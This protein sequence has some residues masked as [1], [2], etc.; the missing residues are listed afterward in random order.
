M[1]ARQLRK[2][3]KL[4]K[5]QLAELDQGGPDPPW[6]AVQHVANSVVRVH[7]VAE[8][9]RK[10]K[11]AFPDVSI[12]FFEPVSTPTPKTA[13]LFKEM[14]ALNAAINRRLKELKKSH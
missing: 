12:K 9:Y 4:L 1:D 5:E 7:R 3:I 14:T 13:E 2:I 10:L 8:Q 6:R 11:L